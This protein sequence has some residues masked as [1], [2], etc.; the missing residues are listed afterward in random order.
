MKKINLDH[1]MFSKDKFVI[2]EDDFFTVTS[3]VFPS[4]VEGLNMENT[5]GHLTV[6]PFMGLIIWDAI[7]DGIS[8]KMKDMFTQPIPGPGIADTYGC[9]QFTSGLLANGTP[10]PEDN[11][12]LHGEFPTSKMDHSYLT[13][14]DEAITIHSDYEYVKGFGYHYL[15]EPSVKMYKNN[16]LFDIKLSV[17]NL[18]NYQPM[19][20]QYMCHMNYAYV[21][22]A[23]INSNIP[24]EAFQLRQTIP[25]HVHPTPEWKAYNDQLKDSGELINKLSDP[26]HYDPEIVFFSKDL[27]KFAANAEFR[28]AIGNG[29]N[30]LTK[31]KTLQFPIATRWLLYNADQQVGAFALPGTSR[32]E[33]F[34][35]AKKAGTLIMLNAHEK[36][37]FQVTTGLEK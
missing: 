8:L 1:R 19:P 30:F 11:Y 7:F 14:E 12:Q 2:Y 26:E 27:T 29:R 3:F 15:S 18:S 33:G 9:F 25:S 37:N 5:K 10:G 21:K 31:F 32:P 35:A 6:L 16:G 36:R 34:T 20:L 4:G 23:V 22:D 13:I 28:M 17:T 24:N